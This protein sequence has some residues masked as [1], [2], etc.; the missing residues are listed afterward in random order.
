MEAEN[1]EKYF[2]N[3]GKLTRFKR[4]PKLL[5]IFGNWGHQRI[6]AKYVGKY[7]LNGWKL[8]RIGTKRHTGMDAENV[9]K[10]FDLKGNQNYYIYLV[11][12][13]NKG[14]MQNMWENIF[15]HF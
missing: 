15:P 5:H 6:D 10:Y 14:L 9:G 8:T 7:F 13:G 1:V 2:L 11:I 12:E 3:G 4:E